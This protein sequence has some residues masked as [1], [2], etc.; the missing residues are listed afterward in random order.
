MRLFKLIEEEKN[1]DGEPSQNR[2]WAE[3]G[4]GFI[5]TFYLNDTKLST[6][7]MMSMRSETDG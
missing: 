4:T 5:S 3:H 6:G 2:V 1:E 7:L